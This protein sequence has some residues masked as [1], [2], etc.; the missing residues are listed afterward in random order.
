M[1]YLEESYI[2]LLFGLIPPLNEAKNLVENPS[3]KRV[4]FVWVICGSVQ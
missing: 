1:E 4:A 2:V 3:Y